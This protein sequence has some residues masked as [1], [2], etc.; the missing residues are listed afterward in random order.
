MAEE[1]TDSRPWWKKKT[2]IG[3]GCY[4]LGT[5]VPLLYPAAPVIIAAGSLVVT[6]ATIGA[7]LQACGG[8]LG[9]YG[10]ATRK[11]GK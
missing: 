2:N 8:V 11:A 9:F 3:A 1:K 5:V 7:I 10:A 6:T 4:F